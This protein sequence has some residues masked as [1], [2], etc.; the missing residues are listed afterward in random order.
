MATFRIKH[1]DVYDRVWKDVPRSGQSLTVQGELL[2]AAEKLWDEAERNGDVNWD[3][4]HER[5]LAFL[6]RHLLDGT[7][8]DQRRQ[9]KLDIRAAGRH[10]RPVVEP[11]MWLRLIDAVCDWCIAYPE[12]I[13]RSIDPDL[14]R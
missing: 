7:L 10:R 11:E 8:A 6:R 5:L 4:G 3:D 13:P 12:P 1:R 9:L 2:R 14:H